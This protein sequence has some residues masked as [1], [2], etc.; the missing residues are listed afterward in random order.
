M[1]A[2]KTYLTSK[3]T[4]ARLQEQQIAEMAQRQAGE[5]ADMELD[6]AVQYQQILGFGGAFTEAS[7]YTLAHMSEAKR[8]EVLRSYFDQVDGLGYTIGRVHIHSCDFAL[9]NY[10]YVEDHDTELR[11]FDISRDHQWVLPLVKD[12]AAVKGSPF[13]MLASPWSP[14]AWMKTNGEMNHGGH[15]EPEYA[16]VWA[17]YYTKF[18]RAYEAAGVPIWGI[19]VQ[20]EPDAVQTW[21][22]CIYS[23]EQE[24]DFIKNHLGPTMHAEGLQ[25]VKILCWDHNRDIIVDRASVV[26]SDPEAAKYVWGTGFHWYVSEEFENVG[27]VHELF[28]N[29]HLLF[30]EGCQEGGIKLGEWF[31]GE[32][33]GRNMI[34]DL[35][36]WTEGYLDWNIVLDETGGPNHVNNLCDAPIIADTVTDTLHYNSSYY[37]IGHFS[38][39]IRPGAVRIGL[40]AAQNPDGIYAT[41]FRNTDGHIAVVVMNESEQKYAFTLGHGECIASH[42][43]PAHSIATYVIHE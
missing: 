24:R 6:P 27:K 1:T 29:N 38:K 25:D 39:F 13:T 34:G 10:T 35:N 31:T 32:R 26:L 22:S 9:E 41:A 2:Y 33:Y 37:Y 43:L 18:I 20:N 21:D 42:T 4:D 17:R 23:A 11:T 30:T 28:P 8:E 3:D 5:N 16:A 36:N 7:A 40:K 12:A 19:T 14:P 15:L